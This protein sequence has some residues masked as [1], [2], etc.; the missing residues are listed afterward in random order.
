MSQ[1]TRTAGIAS[2]LR[3]YYAEHKRV[4]LSG[5]TKAGA[6]VLTPK[7]AM[8]C[9]DYMTSIKVCLIPSTKRMYTWTCKQ[10]HFN[11]IAVADMLE[12]INLSEKKDVR[13]KRING[14]S[15]V[16]SIPSHESLPTQ[17]DSPKAPD[18]FVYEA[19]TRQLVKQPNVSSLWNF[20]LDEIV[21]HLELLGWE[22]MLKHVRK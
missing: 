22:V 20:S 12:F 11:D 13:K 9:F 8:D 16:K 10:D 18:G 14:I 6:K 1:N 15:D 19:T 21:N 17:E 4:S 2:F 3:R 5:F 7:E